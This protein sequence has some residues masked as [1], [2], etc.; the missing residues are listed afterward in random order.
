MVRESMLLTVELYGLPALLA[1]ER[2]VALDAATLRE[3]VQVLAD[4][5]PALR[6]TVLD[7]AQQWLNRGYV[8]VVDGRFTRDPNTPLRPGSTVILVAAQAGG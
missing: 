2:R 3:L 5:Y 7:P 4:R 6:G 8:F 1:G